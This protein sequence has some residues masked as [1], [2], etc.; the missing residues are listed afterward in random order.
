[1]DSH[2]HCAFE[3]L[4]IVETRRRRRWTDEEKRRIVLESMSGPRLVSETACRHG[5]SRTLLLTS[6]RLMVDEMPNGFVPAVAI[7]EAGM[8]AP[9][10]P[11]RRGARVAIVLVDGRRLIVERAINGEVILRLARG[12]EALR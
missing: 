9:L 6:R 7:P 12:L 8:A 11:E 4:E 3:R 2:T 10:P 5:I 1:M